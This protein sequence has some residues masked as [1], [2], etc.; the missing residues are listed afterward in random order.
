MEAVQLAQ[1]AYHE[2]RS[3]R[4]ELSKV[5]KQFQLD[6]PKAIEV[7]REM[8]AEGYLDKCLEKGVP[9]SEV[10]DSICGRLYALAGQR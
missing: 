9:Y 5:L 8:Y 7:A 4:G 6:C 1:Q 3:H 10:Y 2:L